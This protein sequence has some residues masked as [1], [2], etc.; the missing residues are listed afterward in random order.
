[1][2]TMAHG[3]AL[4]AVA[5]AIAL[6]ACSVGTPFVRPA[7]ESVELGRTTYRQ[8][9]DRFGKPDDDKPMR[10]NDVQIRSVSWTYANNAD[11]PKMPNT[12]G[13]RQL[14]FLLANDVVVAERFVSSFA[15]DHTDFDEKKATGIV[16]GTTRCEQVIA[17]MGPPAARAIH[18]AV[19]GTS[20]SLVGYVF[21]YAKRPLLQFDFYTKSLVVECGPDGVAKSVKYSESGTP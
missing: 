18:P 7:P 10:W 2:K 20:D 1:M 19:E 4:V 15:V 17:L 14:E 6:A 9:V 11:A 8:L 16:E 21:Q 13:I 3:N 12:L 5:S